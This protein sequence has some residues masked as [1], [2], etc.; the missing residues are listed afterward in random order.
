[1]FF[2]EGGKRLG[3]IGESRC[4]RGKK[5]LQLSSAAIEK[6]LSKSKPRTIFMT[7]KP[8]EEFPRRRISL[9]NT[10]GGEN[11]PPTWRS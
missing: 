6:R 3:G 4:P 8:E 9:A 10:R 11:P 1:M 5:G 7:G 2:F